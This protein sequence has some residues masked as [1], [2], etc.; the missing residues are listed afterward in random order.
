[1]YRHVLLIRFHDSATPD[2]LAGLM[3]A[4]ERMPERVAGLSAVEW[5]ENDSPEG[6]NAGFSH[7]V[8]MTFADAA[9]RDAY[10]PHPAHADLKRLFRPLL[11]EL[12]VVD[13][14]PRRA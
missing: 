11:A 2:D 7:C 3:R 6:K 5:G 13:Y 10:L 4:F 1:M 14:L 12:V 9:A 8:L